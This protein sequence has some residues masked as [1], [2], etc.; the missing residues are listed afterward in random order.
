MYIRVLLPA[1]TTLWCFVLFHFQ[2]AC[3]KT[4]PTPAKKVREYI[5]RLHPSDATRAPEQGTRQTKMKLNTLDKQSGKLLRQGDH[6]RNDN[7]DSWQNTLPR[8]K[9]LT[10]EYSDVATREPQER[11]D[12]KQRGRSSTEH[13]QHIAHEHHS[14]ANKAQWSPPPPSPSPAFPRKAIS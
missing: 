10:S 2:A 8:V 1:G 9:D 7:K 11:M 4:S 3:A 5:E 12:L 6:V 13:L 14:E